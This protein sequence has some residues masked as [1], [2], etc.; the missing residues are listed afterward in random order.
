MAPYAK[1]QALR[2]HDDAIV[3]ASADPPDN[4]LHLRPFVGAAPRLYARVFAPE[5]RKERTGEIVPFDP[6]R[7]HLVA[8]EGTPAELRPDE[9]PYLAREAQ[10]L[11]VLEQQR[12][13]PEPAPDEDP[14]AYQE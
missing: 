2:L 6:A 12:R 10:A 8:G 14:G 11:A 3:V 9:P 1:S 4:K 13:E 7:A 5:K